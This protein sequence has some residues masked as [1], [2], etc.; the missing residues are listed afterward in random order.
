MLDMIQY[1][2][3]LGEAGVS[4]IPGW[5][6]LSPDQ[7][8]SIRR[9]S[10]RRTPKGSWQD[11]LMIQRPIQKDM[12][13][14]FATGGLVDIDN[15]IAEPDERIDRMTGLPYNIQAGAAF[16]D[17]EDRIGFA[18]G[19]LVEK[20]EEIRGLSDKEI[21]RANVKKNDMYRLLTQH[22]EEYATLDQTPLVIH[23]QEELNDLDIKDTF[24]T[25]LP[26]NSRKS[27]LDAF[28]DSSTLGLKV[29]ESPMQGNVKLGGR[30]HF[31]NLLTLNIDEV[32]PAAI[33][34]R[35]PLIKSSNVKAD[36]LLVDSIIDS[37]LYNLGVRDT[38]L[39]ADDELTKDKEDVIEQSKSF[40]LRHGLL[41]LGFDAIKYN[42]GYVLLR[43]NQFMPTEIMGRDARN[44]GGL[45]GSLKKQRARYDRG[46]YAEER[47]PSLRTNKKEGGLLSALK[48]KNNDKR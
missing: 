42:N 2:Q 47:S 45:M 46:G 29:S 20:N 33:Q 11:I 19:D 27:K 37:M 36:P 14:G 32:T 44:Q 24:Y 12:S 3:T 18:T 25:S 26:N 34:E 40:I 5:A 41:R 15:A 30:I 43:E 28:R 23:S 4:F 10:R 9:A 17:E 8:Q 31:K 39:E 21:A 48:K 13:S 7:R 22:E 6:A 16:Q 35:L 1:R 38:V